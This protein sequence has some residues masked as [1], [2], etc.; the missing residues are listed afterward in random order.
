M[1]QCNLVSINKD[2]LNIDI[3]ISNKS[4]NMALYVVNMNYNANNNL[5]ILIIAILMKMEQG[6]LK[7][8]GG[9]RVCSGR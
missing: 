1:E 5:K 2:I 7:T 4:N 6:E 3:L 9:K 8:V